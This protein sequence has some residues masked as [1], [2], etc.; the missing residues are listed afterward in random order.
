MVPEVW[1]LAQSVAVLLAHQ[2]GTVN[3]LYSQV[4]YG[5]RLTDMEALPHSAVM[6][7]VTL[8]R[9]TNLISVFHHMCL[10]EKKKRGH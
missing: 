6:P 4:F 5:L 9:V 10:K 1:P 8:K 3:D 2:A 7:H